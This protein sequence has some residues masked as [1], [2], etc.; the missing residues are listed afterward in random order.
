MNAWIFA[1]L[2]LIEFLFGGGLILTLMRPHLRI[3][4]P[5]G[6][7]SWQYRFVWLL[8]G[9]S[10]AGVFL[11]GILD[12]NSAVFDHWSRF[13]VGGALIIGG[14]V[15]ALW[16]VRTL[17]VH[18]SLGLEGELVTG[19]PYRYSR[20]PQYVGDI[21]LLIGYAVV[22]NSWLALAGA[23]PLILWLYL[24]PRAEEPWL[25]DEYGPAFDVYRNRVAR[26]ID[27]GRIFGQR[28]EPIRP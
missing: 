2:L 5:P 4:P 21:A 15:F 11:I 9:L 19:G 6:R 8:T 1:G 16:G 10:T 22:S 12:W 23:V 3:W 26:F 25:R 17:S 27:W 13:L 7:K 28:E 14:A 24:A 18:A 20:N